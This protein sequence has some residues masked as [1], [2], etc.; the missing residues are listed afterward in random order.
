MQIDEMQ[1][2]GIFRPSSSKKAIS[3][4]RNTASAIAGITLDRIELWDCNGP[5][6]EW[7]NL[8][9]ISLCKAQ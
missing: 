7:K 5:V 1:G 8:K 4:G 6:C 3:F 9:G 2:R